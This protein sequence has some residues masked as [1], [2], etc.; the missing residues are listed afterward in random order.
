[1]GASDF[2]RASRSAAKEA[3]SFDF[4]D[5]FYWSDVEFDDEVWFAFVY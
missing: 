5:F 4:E 2:E 1:L 3:I